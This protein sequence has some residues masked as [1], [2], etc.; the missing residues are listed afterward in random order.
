MVSLDDDSLSSTMIKLGDTY[1]GSHSCTIQ[2]RNGAGGNAMEYIHGAAMLHAS[3]KDFSLYPWEVTDQQIDEWNDELARLEAIANTK[4]EQASNSLLN[5]LKMPEDVIM[6]EKKLG[7]CSF[8][9]K[10]KRLKSWKD[11]DDAFE[12]DPQKRKRPEVV[13]QDCSRKIRKMCSKRTR[14]KSGERALTK[15]VRV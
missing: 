14:K 2:K 11:K 8:W 15:S 3:W 10:C 5:K 1:E 13:K 4:E 12:Y 9:T 6:M 7:G